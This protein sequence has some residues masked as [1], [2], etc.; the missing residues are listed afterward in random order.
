MLAA[1]LVGVVA[2]VTGALVAGAF[3]S[4][5]GAFGPGGVLLVDAGA[6]AAGAVTLAGVP[7]SAFPGNVAVV[8]RCGD[9]AVSALFA[10]VDPG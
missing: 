5:A 9:C 6:V 8:P 7:V 4:V 10:S 1:V 2:L 3:G